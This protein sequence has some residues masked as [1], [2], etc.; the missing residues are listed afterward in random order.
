MKKKDDKS[1]WYVLLLCCAVMAWP[2][3]MMC[4]QAGPEPQQ[5]LII[6][7]SN[8]SALVI[9]VVYWLQEEVGAKRDGVVGPETT[10]LVN[11]QSK[12]DEPE[13]FNKYAAKFM[14]PSGA[15]EK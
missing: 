14:T 2:L 9:E 11:A 7:D 6:G 13:L 3:Y 4:I 15:K 10:Q 8:E 1:I 12:L 5:P